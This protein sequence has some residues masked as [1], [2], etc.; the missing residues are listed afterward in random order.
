MTVVV[1]AA[2]EVFFVFF[3]F[4]CMC[5]CVCVYEFLSIVNS[6]VMLSFREEV[7]PVTSFA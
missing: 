7:S 2:A 4:V 6:S 5:V 3:Y 1:V